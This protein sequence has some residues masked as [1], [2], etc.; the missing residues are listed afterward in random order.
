MA[1]GSGRRK[2]AINARL[3]LTSHGTAREYYEQHMHG[4]STSVGRAVTLSL[5]ARSLVADMRC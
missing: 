1:C 3:R 5:H 2:N 4:P